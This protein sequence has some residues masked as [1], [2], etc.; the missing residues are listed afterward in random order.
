MPSYAADASKENHSKVWIM[1]APSLHSMHQIM[2]PS[3]HDCQGHTGVDKPPRRRQQTAERACA[4]TMR[5]KKSPTTNPRVPPLGFVKATTRPSSNAGKMVA[6]I[7]A[8]ASRVATSANACEDSTSSKTTP[9]ISAVNPEAPGAAPFRARRKLVSNALL[10]SA[11]IK[12]GASR[13]YGSGLS[14]TVDTDYRPA[15]QATTLP[16]TCAARSATPCDAVVRRLAHVLSVL[17]YLE[18]EN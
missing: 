2:H 10:S 11:A 17:S 18:P 14:P 5:L 16:G 9:A 4:A 7:C 12:S 6:G 13:P 3:Q 8:C 15:S 1:C